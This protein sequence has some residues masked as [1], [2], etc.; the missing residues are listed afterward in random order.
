M[1]Q[2]HAMYHL[3]S[4]RSGERTIM[5]FLLWGRHAKFVYEDF[6]SIIF[7]LNIAIGNASFRHVSV[8]FN[9]VMLSLVPAVT[10]LMGILLVWIIPNLDWLLQFF[11]FYWLR[12]RLSPREKSWLETSRCIQLICVIK[13][14][15]WPCMVQCFILSVVLGEFRE[16]RKRWYIDLSPSINAFPMAV[17]IFSGICAFSLNISSLMANNWPGWHGWRIHIDWRWLTCSD[18]M[19]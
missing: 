5:G 9:Q 2:R 8:N 17:V 10:I 16:I 4:N 12:P 1:G 15:P 11:A 14:Q 3:F 13:W 18:R 19:A 7:S 6:F